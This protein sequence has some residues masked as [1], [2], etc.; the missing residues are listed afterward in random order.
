[1]SKLPDSHGLDDHRP[2]GD[3]TAA[4]V[5]WCSRH[6]WLVLAIAVVAGSAFGWVAINRLSI[7]TDTDRLLSEKLIWRQ[8]E[9]AFDKEF[10]QNSDLIA[11]VVRAPTPEQ[12]E[13]ATAQL[14]AKLKMSP[15]FTSVS[16]PDGG[17]FFDRNGLLLLPVADVQNLA[18]SMIKAQPFIGSIAADPSLRGLGDTLSLALEGIKRGD[19]DR[20]SLTTVLDGMGDAVSENLEPGKPLKLMSWQSMLTGR[21]PSIT[22]LQRFIQVKPVLDFA[23]LTPGK[24]ATDFIRHSAAEMGLT[25]ANGI[26]IKLT[27]DVPLN[28]EQFATVSQGLGVSMTVAVLLVAALLYGALRS[29]RMALAILFTLV[30]GLLATA[31]F[32]AL[33][34]HTLNLISV[35]F[36][37]LF[38]GIAVDFGIQ[39]S[40]RYRAQRHLEPDFDKA[41]LGTARLVGPALVLAAVAAGSGFFSFLPTAYRGVSELG[42]I[43]GVGMLIAV[44]F[45]LTLLPALMSLLRLRPEP[46]PVGFRVL[47]GLDSFLLRRRRAVLTVASVLA[48]GAI[49]LLPRLNFDFNPLNLMDPHTEAVSVMMQLMKNPDTTPNT[50]DVLKPSLE[51]ANKAADALS[52]LPEVLRAVT[53]SSYIPE[54]QPEKLAILNDANTL[55]GP[56]LDPAQIKPAPTPAQIRTALGKCSAALR[57]VAPAGDANAPEARLANLFDKTAAS[58][59]AVVERIQTVLLSGLI[60][61]FRQLRLT[62]SATT[63]TMADLPPD[64]VRSWVAPDGS[65][66]ASIFPAGNANDNDVLRKFVTAVQAVVPDATGTPVSIQQSSKT[67]VDAFMTAG[68]LATVGITILLAITLRRVHD[69]VV[70]LIPLLL[71]A[72]FTLATTVVIGMPLN[73]ANI[74][75]LPLLLGIGV[76][77]DIYFVMNWRAGRPNPLQSGT[78]RAIVFSALTTA[79]AFGSLV[80]SSHPGTSEMGR[81]LSIEVFYTLVCVLLIMPSLLGAPKQRPQPGAAAVRASAPELGLGRR[82]GKAH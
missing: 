50:I 24:Q 68:G 2:I 16:R 56:T 3:L 82:A 39:F 71:A 61:E 6:A 74:I 65:A 1:V 75:A 7:D 31:A 37:I 8:R 72:L 40:V 5:A 60:D 30:I 9:I 49:A 58:S 48:I 53:L 26:D 21:K 59:D 11:V 80:L 41:L 54:D 33:A 55:I 23:S 25:P 63:V 76:A 46:R 29:V 78:A 13:S 70:A 4:I 52:K 77:F 12:A 22:D 14:T 38:V 36:A 10:P 51:E 28:D 34:V 20:A 79:S 57:K 18:D 45:N 67:I 19:A 69:V 66:R 73:F 42:I 27:G 81:L 35:A 15:L 17:P 32:A 44:F 47:A 62:L 43:A 64:L